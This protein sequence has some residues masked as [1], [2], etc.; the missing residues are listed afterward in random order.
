MEKLHSFRWL[1]RGSL[2]PRRV[3]E[4][5]R[6]GRQEGKAMTNKRRDCS[7][8]HIFFSGT[9][10]TLSHISVFLGERFQVLPLFELGSLRTPLG[11]LSY[12]TFFRP[13]ARVRF[14]TCESILYITVIYNIALPGRIRSTNVYCA[15]PWDII[16]RHR[17]G[18]V[19]QMY[20]VR[21]CDVI[22][23][24]FRWLN[25][26]FNLSNYRNF[27]RYIIQ[28]EFEVVFQSDYRLWN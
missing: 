8:T 11:E 3:L 12:C 17:D 22:F 13:R 7:R 10:K 5:L 21:Y 16:M 18:F 26:S 19:P 23:R 28:Y 4:F 14:A 24:V 1:S 15:W 6:S 27:Q 25:F 9:L 2:R 20:T